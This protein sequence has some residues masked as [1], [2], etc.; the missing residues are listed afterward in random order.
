[1]SKIVSGRIVP[2]RGGLFFLDFPSQ[3]VISMIQPEN[4]AAEATLSTSIQRRLEHEAVCA[5][6]CSG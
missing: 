3:D 4:L 1:M 2:V 5:V 6:I